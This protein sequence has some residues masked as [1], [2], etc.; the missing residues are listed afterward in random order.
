MEKKLITICKYPLKFNYYVTDDGQVWSERSHKF[1]SQSKDKDGYMKVVLCS[2]DLPPKKVHRYSVHRLILENFYPVPDMDKLQVN[3]ID[4]DKTNNHLANL[5]WVTC[6]EN[7]HHAIE[8]G[9]RAKV[10][11]AAKLTP[12][13]VKE[14][15]VRGNHGERNVDLSKEYG[16]H[17]DIIGKIKNRKMWQEVTSSLK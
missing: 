13:Q 4:G 16:V 17:P 9:L 10:N 5:E 3:H 11:G 12:N 1:L 7:I 8:N 15:Y 14:I 6:E 2:T